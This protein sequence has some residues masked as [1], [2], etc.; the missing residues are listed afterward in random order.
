MNYKELDN[1]I[2][3]KMGVPSL[4]HIM[5]GMSSD[6][7]EEYQTALDEMNTDNYDLN[8][9]LKKYDIIV[10]RT[11]FT[12]SFRLHELTITIPLE[13]I[14]EKDVKMLFNYFAYKENVLEKKFSFT[15]DTDDSIKD[16]NVIIHF[17]L[18][19]V[20]I[21]KETC[22]DSGDEYIV[23]LFVSEDDV[24]L[25]KLRCLAIFSN[26]EKSFMDEVIGYV[27]D[28]VNNYLI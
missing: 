16:L 14:K 28:S 10:E 12:S 27:N 1:L 11:A 19:D 22:T 24:N 13:Q 9:F 25:D 20:R 21:T 5:L 26:N 8:D 15:S 7:T 17:D 3:F 6:E 23:I 2:T 4:Y 18:F